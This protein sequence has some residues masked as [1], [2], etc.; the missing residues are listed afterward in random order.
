MATATATATATAGGSVK[1]FSISRQWQARIGYAILIAVLAYL[2]VLPMIRLQMLA[3]EDGGAGYR[4]QYGR[5]D[6][7]EAI[8]T[9]IAL[10]LGS[11]VIAMVLGTVLAFAASRL[12]EKLGWLRIVPILPIVMPAVANIVGWAFLLSPGPGYLNVLLRKLPWWSGTDTG[13]IDVYTIPWIVIL[14]GFGLT[15]FVYLFVSSGMQNISSEHLEAAQVSGSSTVG[16]FFKI[17]LPLLRPSLIYGGG[18]ALLLGLGQFTGPLLLGQNS[19]VKVLTTE[20]YRRVSESPSDF[21]AAA[22]AGS[23]LVIFGLVL[24]LVQKVLLGNQTRFVTHGGKAFASSTGRATWATATVVIFSMFALVIPLIGLIIVSLTPYWSGSLSWGLLTLDNFREL[25]STSAITESVVTSV[26][27]SLGAVIICIPIGYALANLLV[28]GRRFKI[29]AL[30]ADLMTA[31]P[32]GIP[33]VIFGVGFLLTYTEPPFILY[34]TRTV[35]ILVYIVLMLPFATRMQMTAMLALGNTYNEASATSGASPFV[36]TLRIML[37]LMRPTVLSAV[38]LMFILLTHE[39]AASLLVRASTTQ[40]MGTL[41]FDMWQNGSYP[42]VAAMALLMTAVTTIGVAI[43][44]LV[45]GRNV[46]SKL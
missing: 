19:G 38:A 10:A 44:M 22:A 46:L 26:L 32:L 41:L 5:Y 14:T 9:T 21:A 15:S 11:L 8:W 31:L 29:L 24:V 35:I 6:V 43:A 27:T 16:I 37:P 28:R 4:T 7:A 17:V 1:S 2:V 42:M 23:P 45:G 39:F 12:P 18:I 33:A 30:L 25:W 36:T 3:F 34:G 40:V 20:M 13:P